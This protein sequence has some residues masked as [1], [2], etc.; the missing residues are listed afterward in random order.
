MLFPAIIL[1]GLPVGILLAPFNAIYSDVG[2]VTRIVLNPIRYATPVMYLIPQTGVW[3]TILAFNPVAAI[4]TSLRSLATLNV[5]EDPRGFVFWVV[6]HGCL[7]LV[8]WFIFHISIPV[9]A[10]KV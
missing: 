5:M 4:L 3:E 6:I 1:A 8:G 10:E 7:F 9:L 2:R